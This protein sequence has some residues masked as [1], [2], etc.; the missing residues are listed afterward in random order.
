MNGIEAIHAVL[1]HFGGK[2][3]CIL[4]RGHFEQ[5]WKTFPLTFFRVY[6]FLL[7]IFSWTRVFFVFEH[8][9]GLNRKQD[10]GLSENLHI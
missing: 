1:G 9:T 6:R 3:W 10:D 4:S 5:I 8:I 2:L 7:S